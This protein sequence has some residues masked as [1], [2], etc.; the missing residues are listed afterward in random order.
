ME[1]GHVRNLHAREQGGP[2]IARL[3]DRRSGRTGKAKA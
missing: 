3:V 2:M 1:P